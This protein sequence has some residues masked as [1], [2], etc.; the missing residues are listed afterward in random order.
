MVWKSKLQGEFGF[1]FR[2]LRC[3]IS[4]LALSNAC[5]MDNDN[6]RN[7]DLQNDSVLVELTMIVRFL[8]VFCVNCLWQMEQK[9]GLWFTCQEF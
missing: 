9:C 2:P 5:D 4:S 7:F 3:W 8:F 6:N 1:T